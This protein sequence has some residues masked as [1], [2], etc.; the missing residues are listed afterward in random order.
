[1]KTNN[2]SSSSFLTFRVFRVFRRQPLLR[3]VAGGPSPLSVQ[4]LLLQLGITL[5]IFVFVGCPA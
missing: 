2:N 1:M 5:C 3:P 4:E